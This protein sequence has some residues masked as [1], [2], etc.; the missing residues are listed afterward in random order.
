REA[1]AGDSLGPGE[2]EPHRRRRLQA[3]KRTGLDEAAR[4]AAAPQAGP[5][6]DGV[7]SRKTY[8]YRREIMKMASR[9][10]KKEK[11]YFTVAEANAALPLVRAIVR[12]ITE[13]AKD[14]RERQGRLT[15]LKP[16]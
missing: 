12:D 15:R 7:S 3:A 9:K 5:G 14:L 10:P 1:A 4:S 16:E 2:P 13:L 6:Q 8:G 11:K